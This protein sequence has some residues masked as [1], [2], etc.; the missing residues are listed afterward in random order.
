MAAAVQIDHRIALGGDGHPGDPFTRIE[1]PVRHGEGKFYAE[2]SVLDRLVRQEQVILRYAR[3]DGA[4]AAGGFPD[5][6][7]G[8][9][10]DI[11]GICDPSGRILGL[12]PSLICRPADPGRCQAREK[13]GEVPRKS[14]HCALDAR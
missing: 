14:L 13:Q 1:L 3:A 7:N 8:S 5:N 2:A 6:P 11:A 12:M 4:P 9:L 10:Y